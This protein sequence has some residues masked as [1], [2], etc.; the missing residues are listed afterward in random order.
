MCSISPRITINPYTKKN[1][2]KVCMTCD[3]RYL[4]D[5]INR[6]TWVIW[7]NNNFLGVIESFSNQS[8]GKKVKELSTWSLFIDFSTFFLRK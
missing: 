8:K 4:L 5:A 2:R 1:Q 7:F 3:Q 6:G